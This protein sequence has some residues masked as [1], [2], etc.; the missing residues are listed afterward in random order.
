[1]R[2][3]FVRTKL[4]S[5]FEWKNYCTNAH[6]NLSAL[7]T[8]G[9]FICPATFDLRILPSCRL[10]PT[11]LLMRKSFKI[12]EYE[13]LFRFE[14]IKASIVCF[15]DRN[16]ISSAS[17]LGIIIIKK[18]KERWIIVQLQIW[19]HSSVRGQFS[20]CMWCRSNFRS[21]MQQITL[22]SNCLLRGRGTGARWGARAIAASMARGLGWGFFFL[23]RGT[24]GEIGPKETTMKKE[25]FIFSEHETR[26]RRV[27]ELIGVS[28]SCF[29]APQVN[30]CSSLPLPASA[31]LLLPSLAEPAVAS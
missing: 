5:L 7:S 21:L 17:D 6:V 18:K 1:M 15:G 23:G 25:T 16:E 20:S 13:Q 11:S 14:I 3:L 27:I 2:I 30:A 28:Y 22:T 31:A 4:N 24:G 10:H 29:L 9:K 26:K 8:S 19:S 12:R